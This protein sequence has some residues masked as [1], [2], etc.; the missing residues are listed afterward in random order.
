MPAAWNVKASL[1]D[2]LTRF[3]RPC[4]LFPMRSAADMDVY[5]ALR[6]VSAPRYAPLG[7]GVPGNRPRCGRGKQ[8]PARGAA[9]RSPDCPDSDD[10]HG[11]NKDVRVRRWVGAL[12]RSRLGAGPLVYTSDLLDVF[13]GSGAKSTS[14]TE[15][16]G[17]A[18][19]AHGRFRSITCCRPSAALPRVL[20]RLLPRGRPAFIA[21]FPSRPKMGGARSSTAS[22]GC[23]AV[24]AARR[25]RP[26]FSDKASATTTAYG[27]R[28]RDGP[29]RRP[30]TGISCWFTTIR[31]CRRRS[32]GPGPKVIE[33]PR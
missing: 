22:G 14:P 23:S 1:R 16:S 3:W 4:K 2:Y 11:Y 15:V 20:T 26:R 13:Q 25:S 8:P 29:E 10:A 33:R 21:V 32:F 18:R 17:H 24:R 12:G 27:R 5:A 7:R 9:F 30:Q 31:T 19:S 6:C 28:F